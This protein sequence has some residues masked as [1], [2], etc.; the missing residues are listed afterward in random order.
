MENFN[1]MRSFFLLA[2]YSMTISH[3]TQDHTLYLNYNNNTFLSALF[4]IKP[5]NGKI[6]QTSHVI[7]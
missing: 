4:T 6:Y 2:R 7:V 3:K 5:T 1:W